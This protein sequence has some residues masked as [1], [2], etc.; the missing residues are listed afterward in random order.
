VLLSDDILE[1]T[2]PMRILDARVDA[3]IV[4]G[5]IVYRRPSS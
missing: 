3:T 4:G 1:R 5:E 2:D